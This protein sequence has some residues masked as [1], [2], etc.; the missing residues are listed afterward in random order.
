MSEIVART[1]WPCSPQTSQN[2]TGA[3]RRL[4]HAQPIEAF[5][6]LGRELAGIGD[7]AEIA[8]DVGHEHRHADFREA[9]GEHLHR[10]RLARAGGARHGTV[11]VGE[12]GQQRDVAVVGSGNDD[13]VG[14]GQRLK[15]GKGAQ[16]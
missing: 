13:R 4:G 9:L 12:C 6:E 10:D 11:A 2:V 8:L 15:E 7:A 1:G 3:P 5:L 14:H 16:V